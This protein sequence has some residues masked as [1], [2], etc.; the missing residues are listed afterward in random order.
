MAAAKKIKATINS[1]PFMAENSLGVLTGRTSVLTENGDRANCFFDDPYDL[2]LFSFAIGDEVEVTVKESKN[3][4]NA[5]I[6]TPVG[7]VED[8]AAAMELAKVRYDSNKCDDQMDRAMKIYTHARLTV[9]E[10]EDFMNS[11]LVNREDYPDVFEDVVKSAT[12]SIFIE[13]NRKNYGMNDIV[14]FE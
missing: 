7:S 12:A 4:L 14:P 3:F 9:L 11:I 13:F 10:N 2:K 1:Q 8:A 6:K 5:T